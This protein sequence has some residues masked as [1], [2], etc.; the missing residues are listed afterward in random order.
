MNALA[1][2]LQNDDAN[3]PTFCEIPCNNVYQLIQNWLFLTPEFQLIVVLI[4][5][6]LALLVA[7]SGMTTDRALRQMQS[8]RRQMVTTRDALLQ[9]T[10]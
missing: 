5:S 10:G 1:N 3:C 4:S 7:L 8:N 6:P 9:G 2:A